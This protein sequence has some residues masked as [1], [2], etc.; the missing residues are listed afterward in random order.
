M[1]SIIDV[2]PGYKMFFF[3]FLNQALCT[4]LGTTHFCIMRD[5]S[6]M[7]LTPKDKIWIYAEAIGAVGALILARVLRGG[8]KEEK[9][10]IIIG[11]G[12]RREHFCSLI[13]RAAMTQY[14]CKTVRICAIVR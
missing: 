11:P 12:T 3:F 14:Q 13:A 8:R 6:Y 10:R 1:N 2:W 7:F 4:K 9:R 5:G